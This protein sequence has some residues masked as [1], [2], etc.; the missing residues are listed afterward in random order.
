MVDS[1]E[2]T[3]LF[4]MSGESGKY[5]KG[6]SFLT[7]SNSCLSYSPALLMGQQQWLASLTEQPNSSL[8]PKLAVTHP[9]AIGFASALSHP[10]FKLMHATHS[11]PVQDL[12]VEG[13]SIIFQK[14]SLK[15]A[16]DCNKHKQYTKL[17]ALLYK[18]PTH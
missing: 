8:E 5:E 4:L 15:I 9:R 1:G 6:C 11:S 7:S 2:Q 17:I 13:S 16:S 3:L 18:M 14:Y 10:A 12:S